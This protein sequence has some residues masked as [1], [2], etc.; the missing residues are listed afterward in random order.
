MNKSEQREVIK[1][2]QAHKLGMSDMVA[3]SL[4]ALIRASM[5]K[6]SRAALLEYADIFGIRNHP[7]FII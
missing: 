1:L 5:T 7:E 2:A 4:S 6:R 3:R